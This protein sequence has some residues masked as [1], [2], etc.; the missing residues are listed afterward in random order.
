MKRAITIVIIVLILCITGC[1]SPRKSKAY[2]DG[3]RTYYSL[4]DGS[5]LCE[6]ISY[7]ERLEIKGTI[8]DRE[9]TYIYLSNIGFPF[10]APLLYIFLRYQMQPGSLRSPCRQV[11]LYP[12]C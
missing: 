2:K 4:S 3:I 6:E 11:C 5:W 9:V 7:K 1:S 12:N 10:N 8:K